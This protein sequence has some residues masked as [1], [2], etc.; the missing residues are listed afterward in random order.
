M[1]INE[2]L[3]EKL[4]VPAPKPGQTWRFRMNKT[5]RHD[6]MT[7]KP[8]ALADYWMQG[9][10][11]I[12]DPFAKQ[13][14]LILNSVG[15]K[16]VIGEFGKVRYEP[17]VEMIKWDHKGE[18]VLTEQDFPTVVFMLR[19]NKNK[20]NPFRDP[21]KQSLYFEVNDVKTRAD[22]IV[23]MDLKHDAY[24]YVKEATLDKLK[25]L[26]KNIGGIDI[27]DT[28]TLRMNLLQR[29]ETDPRSIIIHSKDVKGRLKINVM[30]AEHY[31]MISFSETERKW[32]WMDDAGED[33]CDISVDK[34]RIDG[35][36]EYLLTQ[37]KDNEAKSSLRLLSEKMKPI[38]AA[39]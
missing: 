38:Y 16:P 29:S 37:D 18:I 22:K 31:K 26:G 24:T 15:E 10:D 2:L 21:K 20:S 4:K 12:Y 32:F 13:S 36:V 27:T 5:G 6:P 1:D 8:L 39:V 35:L 30:D 7:G 17:I 11:I 25:A 3:S 19:S 14:I 34:G 23:S 33:I 28:D 9:K